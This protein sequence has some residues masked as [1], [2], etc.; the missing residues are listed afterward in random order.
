MF[1]DLQII[2]KALI[3]VS[4][5]TAISLATWQEIVIC[6][7]EL[8]LREAEEVVDLLG[9]E[10]EEDNVVEPKRSPGQIET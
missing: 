9:S 3:M 10:E 6:L 2:L 1:L 4:V 5:L 8:N 7:T